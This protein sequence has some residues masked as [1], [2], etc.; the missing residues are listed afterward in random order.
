MRSKLIALLVA[1]AKRWKELTAAGKKPSRG[2]CQT[3]RP[4]LKTLLDKMSWHTSPDG[5]AVGLLGELLEG[6]G[7][8]VNNAGQRAQTMNKLLQQAGFAG[9]VLEAKLT[10]KCGRKAWVATRAT[11]AALY[12]LV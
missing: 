6:Q 12:T 7:L 10:G 4:Q 5:S 11:F 8:A 2:R 3:A 1:G 9:R